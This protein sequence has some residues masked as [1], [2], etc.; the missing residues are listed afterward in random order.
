MIGQIF[1]RVF[2]QSK[3][4]SGAFGASQFTPK[5]FFGTFSASNNSGSP[6]EGGGVPPNSPTHP[7]TPP[8]TPPPSG[9]LC[10]RNAVCPLGTLCLDRTSFG[11]ACTPPP[12]TPKA[13]KTALA[14]KVKEVMDPCRMHL[15]E[16]QLVDQMFAV[17]DDLPDV[18]VL[19]GHVRDRLPIFSFYFDQYPH[20]LVGK[21]LNDFFGVQCRGGC[22]CAGTYAHV[23]FGV[24][25]AASLA[26]RDRVVRGDCAAKPGW[27]RISLHPTTTDREVQ[28]IGAALQAIVRDF[29]A[30]SAGYAQDTATGEFL[31]HAPS[32]LERFE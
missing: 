32:L 8:W 21:L 5:N 22:S 17:L 10:Q 6:E 29:D 28:R 14:I 12:T 3:I 11:L 19:E 24:D 27:V 7:P 1:L 20:N 23:L 26:L 2:S 25:R 16:Q 18:H 4:F 15:R 30:Y 31:L 13:I 9:K